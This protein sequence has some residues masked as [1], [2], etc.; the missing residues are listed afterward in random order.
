MSQIILALQK[1]LQ[2]L[3]DL[4]IEWLAIVA[5]NQNYVTPVKT[6]NVWINEVFEN[7]DA[8]LKQYNQCS[9]SELHER[10][11]ALYI[12]A[13]TRGLQKQEELLQMLLKLGL[14]CSDLEELE[15]A[16]GNRST[17]SDCWSFLEFIFVTRA[18]VG[19][20]NVD[21]KHVSGLIEAVKICTQMTKGLSQEH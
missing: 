20:L 17:L 15:Q 10:E 7:Q 19:E 18:I 12:W 6:A 13:V 14:S 8:L 4:I 11:N 21:L 1:H 16:M 2:L 5:Q 9:I 3:P